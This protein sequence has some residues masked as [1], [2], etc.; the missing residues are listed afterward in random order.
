MTCSTFTHETMA[1]KAA[2]LQGTQ[3]SVIFSY[4][5]INPCVPGATVNRKPR[6]AEQ[7]LGAGTAL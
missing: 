4:H 6:Q 7:L 1:E 2:G 5:A 3:C